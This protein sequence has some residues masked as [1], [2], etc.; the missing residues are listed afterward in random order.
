LTRSDS[1]GCTTR[2][3][4]A[5]TV[6]WVWTDDEAFLIGRTESRVYQDGVDPL[7]AFQANECGSITPRRSRKGGE[8]VRRIARAK[9][10][11]EG[12]QNLAAYGTVK[13]MEANKT[14]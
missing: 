12:I 11:L 6:S 5:A 3:A 7:R 1:L 10:L 14:K 2:V 9:R 13:Y 8:E 4:E